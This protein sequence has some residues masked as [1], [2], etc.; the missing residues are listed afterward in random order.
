MRSLPVERLVVVHLRT[1]VLEDPWPFPALNH[2]SDLGFGEL[3]VPVRPETGT[4][5]FTVKPVL[6]PITALAD[7]IFPN[8]RVAAGLNVM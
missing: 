4:I 8:V 6:D 5:A 3:T 7:A 2:I 1:V